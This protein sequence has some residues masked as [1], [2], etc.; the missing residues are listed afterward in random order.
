[1]N[2][3]LAEMWNIKITPIT[4]EPHTGNTSKIKKVFCLHASVLP[5]ILVM[6]LGQNTA[7]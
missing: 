7:R 4:R 2:L 5:F 6:I 3:C 1:M